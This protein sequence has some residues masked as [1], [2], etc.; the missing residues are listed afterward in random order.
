MDLLPGWELVSLTDTEIVQRKAYGE[1]GGGMV[2]IRGNPNT[3]PEEHKKMADDLATFIYDCVA[4][5]KARER[6]EE[7]LH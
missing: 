6:L 1:N 3:D 4:K 7:E 2:I 5:A